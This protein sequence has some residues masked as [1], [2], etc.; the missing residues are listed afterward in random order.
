M[1]DCL[2]TGV[3]SKKRKPDF[4]IACAFLMASDNQTSPQDAAFD[5]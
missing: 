4:E 3:S 2:E 1:S 5:M